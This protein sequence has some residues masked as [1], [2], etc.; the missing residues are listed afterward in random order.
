MEQSDETLLYDEK[1]RNLLGDEAVG[2]YFRI[3]DGAKY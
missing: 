2:R 3:T 1:Q